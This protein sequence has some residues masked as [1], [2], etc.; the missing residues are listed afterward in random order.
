MVKTF[1]FRRRRL[2]GLD[3]FDRPQRIRFWPRPKRRPLQSLLFAARPLALAAALGAIWVGYDPAIIDPPSLLSRE[4][5]RVSL[6]F[7]RCGV[8]RS[9]ACV[10]DGDTFRLGKR[11][12]RIIGIDAPETHPARC[13][14]E[15]RLGEA[16][17]VKLQQL[18]N[19]GPF[20]MVAPAYGST[21]KYGRD[22]R[23]VQRKRPDGSW[24]SIATNMRESGLAHRYTGFKTGWC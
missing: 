16:A 24:Q 12:V 10:V 1:R 14:E 11:R 15:A 3:R 23:T 9:H 6:T 17:T 8:G 4:P 5:E 7:G 21:D 22:L 2:G 20:E 13:T 18:L 19:Q